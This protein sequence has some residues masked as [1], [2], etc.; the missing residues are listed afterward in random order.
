MALTE[1]KLALRQKHIGAS[2]SAAILGLS[3]WATPNDVFWSKRP[4]L[5]GID[6]LPCL[7]SLAAE[8]G[9]IL[10]RSVLDYAQ[11]HL[12]AD[13][14]R[15]QFRVSKGADGGIM[16]ATFDA[17]IPGRPREAVE[18]KTFGITW[19]APHADLAVWGD[20]DTDQ[21]PESYIVQCQHQIHVGELDR[22]WLYALL[23]GR[24]FVRYRIERRDALIDSL[25]AIVGEFWND[26]V[27][28]G[29]PPDPTAQPPLELLK[30]ARREPGK[31]ICFG[32]ST[33]SV[34]VAWEETKR[35]I[36]ELE[37]RRD[38]L[39]AE[40]VNNLGDAESAIMPDNRQFTFRRQTQRRLD[41][42]RLRTEQPAIAEQYTIETQT[43]PVARI[44]KGQKGKSYDAAAANYG[45]PKAAAIPYHQAG[46]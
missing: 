25:V 12:G 42:D 9:I 22:V 39:L 19:A 45:H 31:Q 27:I 46:E 44:L 21:V 23:G 8:A 4:D 2:E 37:E 26:H 18:A 3:R 7:S 16:S 38:D 28:P 36:K 20:P 13:L 43:A 34:V 10:E 29:V 6:R 41:L 33:S 32:I 17:L 15:N 24:G 14:L 1:S 5:L 11:R 35:E 40:I 30:A